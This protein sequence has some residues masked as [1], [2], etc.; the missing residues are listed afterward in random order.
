M[1]AASF[2]GILLA[3]TL[4][5]GCSPTVNMDPI[6]PQTGFIGRTDTITYLA[7]GSKDVVAK[8]AIRGFSGECKFK[9]KKSNIVDVELTL[10][11]TAQLGKAGTSVKE[12]ELPYFI[13]V[14][15]PDEK[16]LQRT[17]FTTKI[18]FDNNG[19]GSSKEEHVIKIPLTSRADAGKYKVVIGFALTHDQL[20]YNEEQQK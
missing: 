6:C 13:G 3:L 8:A 14:L 18:S 16:I 5:A 10:P 15:S 4:L 9:D 20:K 17:A 12:K 2:S 19:G 7:P 11:F 1:R